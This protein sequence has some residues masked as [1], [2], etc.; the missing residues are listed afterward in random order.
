M[1]VGWQLAEHMRTSL[2]TDA[3][4]MASAA[5]LGVSSQSGKNEPWRSL[6][7]ASSTVPARVSHSRAR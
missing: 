1:V 3:L 6:G 5:A 7:T 2:V 4:A